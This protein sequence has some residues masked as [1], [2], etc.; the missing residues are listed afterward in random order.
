MPRWHRGE[1][2]EACPPGESV[3]GVWRAWKESGGGKR[4]YLYDGIT[5]VCE[6]DDDGN[7]AA[8]TTFGA[9]GLVSRTL[10]DDTTTRTIYYQFG[11]NGDVANR[12]DDAGALLASDLYDAY[13]GLVVSKTPTG[14]DYDFADDPYGYKGQVG[15]YTDGETGLILCTFRYYDPA[16][17]RWLTRDPIGYA[18]G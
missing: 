5:P 14:Q 13:G 7:T 9:D 12:T 17:G 4:Y 6:L 1:G 16:T 2:P 11:L 8:V 15:Y 3:D 18:G 10:T